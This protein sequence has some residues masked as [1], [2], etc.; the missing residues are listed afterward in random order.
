MTMVFKRFYTKKLKELYV[1]YGKRRG[2]AYN[3]EQIADSTNK[4]LDSMDRHVANLC[5]TQIELAEQ[6]SINQ[7]SVKESPASSL[8]GTT[9]ATDPTYQALLTKLNETE[10]KFAALE[11]KVQTNRKTENVTG[12]KDNNQQTQK[13]RQLKYYCPTCRVNTTHFPQMCRTRRPS[14]GHETEPNG[15]KH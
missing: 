9:I 13:G 4:R 10:A 12:S 3:A 15:R 7:Q 1:D 11:A 8:G 2:R 5:E 6:M 14:N